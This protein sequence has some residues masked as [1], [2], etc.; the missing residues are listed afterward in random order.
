[1]REFDKIEVEEVYNE[2]RLAE[3]SFKEWGTGEKTVLLAPNLIIVAIHFEGKLMHCTGF[4]AKVT[5]VEM[6]CVKVEHN[7][8]EFFLELGPNIRWMEENK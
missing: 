1:M 5:Q 6:N 3:M 2:E 7:G 8:K 4:T